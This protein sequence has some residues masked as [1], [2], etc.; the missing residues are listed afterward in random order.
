[1]NMTLLDLN[2]KSITLS[3]THTLEA[4][5]RYEMALHNLKIQM[6][7]MIQILLTYKTARMSPVV[8]QIR[9]GIE[10]LDTAQGKRRKT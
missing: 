8:S 4:T 7:I 6:V 1:M 5:H 9:R 3:G 2:V 10:L